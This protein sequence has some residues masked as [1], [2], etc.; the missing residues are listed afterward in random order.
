MLQFSQRLIF[1]LLLTAL[2]LP[3][4][5]PAHAQ[6]TVN[7]PVDKGED[8][9]QFLNQTLL[10]Y[11]QLGTQQQIAS[12]PS[13][14]IF[15]NSSRRLG[16][17]VVRLAFDFARARAQALA[18]RQGASSAAA[19]D[20]S[21]AASSSQYQRFADLAAKADQQVKQSK[22]ELEALRAQLE[23]ATP[24][25][26]RVLQATVDETQSEVEFH[27]ARRD[28][29][30]SMMQVSSGSSS[31]GTG[32]LAAQIEELARAIPAA[33]AAPA[34]DAASD[35]NAASGNSDSPSVTGFG[36]STP[37]GI[38]AVVSDIF[39]VRKK[40]RIL[41]DNLQLTAELVK[42]ARAM[43]APLLAHN[44][45]LTQ[46][47]DQLSAQALPQDP[48][49][50][51]Q[52]SKDL[53]ALTAQYKQLSASLVPLGRQ[54]ILLDVYRRDASNW[55]AGLQ[56]QYQSELKSLALRLAGLAVV[57]ALVFVISELWRRAT[58]R[59]ITDTRRRNQFLVV[60]RIVLW[61][62]VAIIVVMALASEL[63]AI[64]TFAGLLTAGIAVALQNVILAV[65]GY[66][67]LVGKYGVR[68]GDR[69]QIGDV[70]G[71]V[72]EIGMVRLH[73]MEVSR[74]VA[75][76]PTGRVVVFSNAVVFQA[77]VGMFKQIPGTSFR[78]HE[79]TLSVGNEGDYRHVEARM[80]E[81]VNKVFA[82]YK[83]KIEA[84]RLSLE[85]SLHSS[86]SSFA[87]EGRLRLTPTG[88]EIVIRYPVETNSAV[89]IDDRVTRALL[90]ALESE[91]KLRLLDSSGPAI[92]L[93]EHPA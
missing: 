19:P 13:D 40:I 45:E 93:E 84:Q 68:V 6:A 35:A 74:G 50:L 4:T 73:L 60:R 75:P 76:R 34:S 1:A 33:A 91:P 89:E 88:L 38:V 17:Q 41:D 69:I 49:A 86:I 48:K 70:T 5:T 43:R 59:Y 24:R 8:I 83:D 46:K 10:W 23:K 71:D 47:G 61:I 32:N 85:R 67:F 92:K 44:R 7:P 20:P 3:A 64:T 54:S 82:D 25:Q 27:Q 78:W 22:K 90:D 81:A 80:M 16:D 28:V 18:V 21:V 66:F 77:G 51:A 42:S 9:I 26:R 30:R 39:S 57:L 55:R 2:L 14:A 63:G 37:S 62:V 87:P 31:P 29:M 36:H 58:F 15:I 53:D 11:R 56:S 65:A 79:V 12:D 52:Q 72:V